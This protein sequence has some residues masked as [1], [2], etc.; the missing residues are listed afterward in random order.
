MDKEPENRPARAGTPGEGPSP[1]ENREDRAATGI[2]GLDAVLGGGLPRNHTYL[3]QGDQGSGK[4]TLGMQF[5][6]AGAEQG[7]RVLYVTTCESEHEIREIARS[8]GWSLDGVTIHYLD[9][10]LCLGDDPKQ[11]VFYPAEVELPKT[12]EML[13]G[14]IDRVDPQRLVIDSLSDIRLLAADPRWFRRQVLALQEDLAR[15]RCT[16]LL[17]DDWLGTDQSARSIVHGVIELEHLAVDYGPD[18]RRLRVAKLRAQP[19]ASGYHDFNIRV[20]GILVYPRLIAAEHRQHFDAEVISSGSPQLDALFG[21]GVDRGTAVLLLG[22]SGNGKSVVATQ[23][24]T[25]AADRAERSAMYIFEERVQTL[26][27]RANGLHLD[28]KMQIDRGLIEIRQIDPAE[29]T[30]GEFA[31]DLCRAVTERGVRMVIIDSLAGYA[32][33]MPNERLLSLHLHELLSYLNQQGVTVLM[34]MTQHGLS[35]GPRYAP[36]DLSYISDSVLLFHTFEHAGELRK[37][38]S[39]YK[40]RG[41][42]H[43]STLR[44]LRLGP[45]GIHVGD[46]LRQFQ[47]VFTGSPHFVGEQLSNGQDHQRC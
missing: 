26:L 35:G 32:N 31:D 42:A 9:V 6:T 46:P 25:A 16:T 34:V 11:S 30:P 14:L 36:F 17:C 41:G 38:I 28:L 12:M 18:R 1:S 7:Q 10:R 13:Q 20:G 33:A 39:V 45:R 21:G 29:V 27:Q 5:C 19:F 44:E 37:A 24:A 8:H 43:E 15:R 4:T 47:G 22:P 3:V 40:R 2:A 23:F